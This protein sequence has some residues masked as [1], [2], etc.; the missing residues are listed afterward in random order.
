MRFVSN[1]NRLRELREE[2]G[3]SRRA[4]AAELGVHPTT[5]TRWE[6][7]AIAIRDDYKQQ[8]AERLGVSVPFLMG[9]DER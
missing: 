1:P 4:L 2:S 3:I 7:G 6:S 8:L 9:W 5:V